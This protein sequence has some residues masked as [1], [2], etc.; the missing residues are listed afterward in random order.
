M[1]DILWANR[2]TIIKSHF[3]QIYHVFEIKSTTH[4]VSVTLSLT[5]TASY[6]K[7]FYEHYSRHCLAVVYVSCP[8]MSTSANSSVNV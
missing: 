5:P 4:A 2:N 1:Q 8:A 3:A 7:S 6:K